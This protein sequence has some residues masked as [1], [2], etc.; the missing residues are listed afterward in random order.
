MNED[1]HGEFITLHY[2]GDTVRRLFLAA[3]IIIAFSI[4]FFSHPIPTSSLISLA[5]V[6]ALVVLAGYTSPR[7]KEVV[8]I[9]ALTSALAILVFG[10]HASLVWSLNYKDW[11]STIFFLILIT[12]VIIFIF[13]LYYSVKS[14]RG[15]PFKNKPIVK[16]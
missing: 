15:M 11:Y 13:A 1:Y 8:A 10:T 6:L 2:Y 4:P 5:L 9:D 7:K 12:L 14:F 16:L 3:G